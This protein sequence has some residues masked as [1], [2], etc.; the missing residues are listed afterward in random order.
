MVNRHGV[1]ISKWNGS[2]KIKMIAM[3]NGWLY[4]VSYQWL[5]TCQVLG[6]IIPLS[7][8]QGKW[9]KGES[10]EVQ[11]QK[12]Q[13]K[14]ILVCRWKMTPLHWGYACGW[15]F[16]RYFGEL[17]QSPGYPIISWAYNCTTTCSI[18]CNILSLGHD[19]WENWV[20]ESVHT[21]SCCVHNNFPSFVIMTHGNYW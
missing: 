17:I 18:I 14:N 2:F 10:F 19:R 3:T 1:C 7:H 12:E 8:W 13:L 20:Y 11:L 6:W 15:L 5:P 16:L 9:F 4:K 21:Q